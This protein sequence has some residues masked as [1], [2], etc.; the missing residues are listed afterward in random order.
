ML[1]E[2]I[3]LVA[4][5]CIDARQTVEWYETHLGMRVAS[6]RRD[7]KKLPVATVG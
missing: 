6:V 2:R 5:R 4:H 3:H 1:I 7:A